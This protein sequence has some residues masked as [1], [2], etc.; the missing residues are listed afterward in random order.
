VSLRPDQ[1]EA[2]AQIRAAF[3]NGARHVLGLFPTGWGKTHLASDVLSGLVSHGGTGGFFT[4]REELALDT[5]AR[6]RANGL[7]VGVVMADEEPDPAAPVQVISIPTARARKL[8]PRLT[9]GIWDECHH[10]GSPTWRELFDQVAG[11]GA[12][13]LGITA[14]AQRGDGRPLDMFQALVHGPSTRWCMDRGL[15]VECDVVAPPGVEE[16]GLVAAPLEAYQRW[17]PDTRALIFCANVAHVTETVAAFAAAGVPAES[18]VGSTAPA[19]RRGARERLASGEVRAL[20]GCGVFIEGF[21]APSAETIILARTF[22]VT[23]TFLQAIGRGLRLFPGK[24]RCTVLDLRGS[25]HAHGLPDEDR[26]WSLSGKAVARAAPTLALRRCP[27]VACGAIFRAAP[28]CPRCG[29]TAVAAQRVPRVLNRAERLAL[30][31]RLPAPERDRR[32]LERL[33]Q[34]AQTRLRKKGFAA[35]AWALA[36]FERTRGR[37]PEGV[38]A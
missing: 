38:A 13:S 10:L 30:L 22:G 20:V 15:L 26:V 16:G 17:A 28:R 27:E 35:R 21:D 14:T 7:R 6:L 9:L 29:A 18:L 33:E 34:I 4:D 12:R 2:R 1:A 25:V 32:Y 3:Q 24:R 19:T 5:A 37:K 8:A 31:E 23:G 36:Q 11:L